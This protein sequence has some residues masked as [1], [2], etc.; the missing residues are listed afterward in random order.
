[1]KLFCEQC[2]RTEAF[3]SV[4]AQDFLTRGELFNNIKFWQR[5]SIQ[6]YVLSFLCQSCKSVP[7]VFLVRRKR[8]K[9]TLCGRAPIEHWT[10]HP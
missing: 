10:F 6:T 7:E 5:D 9:L 2:G 8:E 4:S 1:M 3:N